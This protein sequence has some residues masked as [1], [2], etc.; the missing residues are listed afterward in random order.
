MPATPELLLKSSEGERRIKVERERTTLGRSRDADIFIPDQWLSRMHAEILLDRGGLVIV[1][2][3]A[4][5]GA[6]E[7][8][9][10]LVGREARRAGLRCGVEHL[11]A[12]VDLH[13]RHQAVVR[14]LHARRGRGRQFQVVLGGQRSHCGAEAQR[15]DGIL[16]GVLAALAAVCRWMTNGKLRFAFWRVSRLGHCLLRSWSNAS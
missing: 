4:A 12:R 2:T 10:E 13:Q 15:D 1:N 6:V 5:H 8:E 3:A 11:H 14:Q 16:H 7:A 9:L